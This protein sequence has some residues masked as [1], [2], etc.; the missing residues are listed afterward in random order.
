MKK[1]ISTHKGFS[2]IEI[3]IS[4]AIFILF[5]LG[6]LSAFIIFNKSYLIFGD[7][8][9]AIFV[10]EEGLEAVKNISESNFDNLTDGI[11]GLDYSSGEWTFSG[12]ADVQGI[13]TREIVVSSVDSETKKI[14]SNVSWHL[15]F[16]VFLLLY[17]S[18]SSCN[19]E[20]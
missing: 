4:S 1:L 17:P 3:I 13:Y 18:F 15:Q 19:I 11:H 16:F 5:T 7:E 20:N 6:L 10:A 12:S 8:I 14:V 9:R 2:I